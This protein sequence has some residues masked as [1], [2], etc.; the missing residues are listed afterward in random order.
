[1]AASGSCGQKGS[2]DIFLVNVF[3]GGGFAYPCPFGVLEIKR[4]PKPVID[5]QVLF[6][7]NFILQ[8]LTDRF[9]T[10][11]LPLPTNVPATKPGSS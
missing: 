7:F 9:T 4:H 3:N 5:L 10:V 2:A 8:P 1:M 11:I 6:F